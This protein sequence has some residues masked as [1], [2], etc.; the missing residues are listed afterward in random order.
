MQPSGCAGHRDSQRYRPK[1]KVRLFDSQH[2]QCLP[3]AWKHSHTRVLYLSSHF[4]PSPR[5]GCSTTSSQAH[6]EKERHTSSTSWCSPCSF[7][8]PAHASQIR[9]ASRVTGTKTSR[10]KMPAHVSRQRR[11]H[12]NV[13]AESVRCQSRHVLII[14]RSAS[15]RSWRND[16]LLRPGIDQ[17]PG[18]S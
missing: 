9:A 8:T 14:A 18:V 15:G 1:H 5:N 10:R 4:W 13:I 2:Q 17:V 11:L 7:A 12:G 16:A 6:C 3:S